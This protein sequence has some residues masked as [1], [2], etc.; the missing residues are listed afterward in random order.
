MSTRYVH[1][2]SAGTAGVDKGAEWHEQLNSFLIK[3]NLSVFH[4]LHVDAIIDRAKLQHVEQFSSNSTSSSIIVYRTLQPEFRYAEYLSS[5]RCFSNRRLLSRFRCGC[6]GLHVDTGRWV[7]TKREDRLCQ[8]CH[9]SRDVED[10]QHFLFS[11]PAYSDVRQK[12]ASLFQQA[13]TVS[14]FFTNSEPN[15]C[16]GFLR[17]CFSLGKSIVST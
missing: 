13:F 17:E 7:D 12:H 14:D 6:Y 10:E 8:V 11:C 3:H 4:K 1:T 9:S 15:A 16:G 5:V 2:F